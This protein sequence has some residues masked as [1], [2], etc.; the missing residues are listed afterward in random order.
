MANPRLGHRL[1]K[2]VIADMISM[3]ALGPLSPDGIRTAIRKPNNPGIYGVQLRDL[4]VH[5]DNRGWLVELLRSDSP[6]FSTFGQ[7][8]MVTNFQRGIVRAF[9]K[10]LRQDEF[11]FVS[12]G[13]IQFVCVDERPESS[14]FGALD[15]MVM[16]SERPQ[17]LYVPRG[18]QHGSM[19]LTDGAQITAITSESYDP[20]APD[21]V[22]VPSDH[23]GD[24][25]TVGGW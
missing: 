8:Y 17:A 4:T 7:L 5:P 10:H 9:H 16:S 19:A 23:Y 2:E 12:S 24:V 25:W 22:R 3:T 6:G 1:T 20:Q 15:V 14:T 11:F 13:T 21:E 18:V